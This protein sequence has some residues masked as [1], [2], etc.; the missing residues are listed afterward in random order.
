MTDIHVLDTGQEGQEKHA[1]DCHVNQ[2]VVNHVV[3]IS[4][5]DMHVML[6]HTEDKKG[7]LAYR[8]NKSMLA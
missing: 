4:Y 5:A 2:V 1:T 8:K 7:E 3:N 6:R